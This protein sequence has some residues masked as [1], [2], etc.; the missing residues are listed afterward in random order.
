MSFLSSNKEFHFSCLSQ[1]LLGMFLRDRAKSLN[2]FLHN[3]ANF[4]LYAFLLD[5]ILVFI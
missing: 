2:V 5:K 3:P 4:K 1:G